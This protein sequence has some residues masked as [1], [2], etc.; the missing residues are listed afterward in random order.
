[1]RYFL[2]TVE[3]IVPD[4]GFPLYGALH[5]GWLFASALI[6]FLVSREYRQASAKKRMVMR[7]TV[8]VLLLLDEL[9][10]VLMLAIGGNYAV[11][12]LPLH[13][14]S[15]NILLIAIHAWKRSSVLD[16]FLYT[17]CI[18]G[19]AAALLFPTWTKLPFLNFMHL[20][21][22]T[23]H[24]LLMLYPI[25]LAAGGDLVPKFREVPKCLLLLI[26]MAIVIYPVN[27]LFDTN[28]MFLMDAESGNPLELFEKWWGNHLLGFPILIA[29][30]LVIMYLPPY[31][32][33][34]LKKRKV[35]TTV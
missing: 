19:A 1:M 16:Q 21:S 24:L 6:I 13:L 15:V 27:L 23:V 14:C 29:L 10:K 8:A 34:Q 4:S 2:D 5:L 25:M 3:T 30:V 12:Y 20:H 18:P 32:F 11:K 22:F 31:L 35:H 9:F 33:R 26:G 28:F 7:R 17:V